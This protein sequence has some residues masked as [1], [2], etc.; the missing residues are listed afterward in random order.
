M[1]A[2]NAKRYGV[3]LFITHLHGG[4][5]MIHQFSLRAI[6]LPLPVEGHRFSYN[7]PP[8]AQKQRRS[9]GFQASSETSLGRRHGSGERW[10][11][12]LDSSSAGIW[13]KCWHLASGN[14]TNAL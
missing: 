13:P 10:A 12:A 11:F 7:Q 9:H 8:Y 14:V 1:L 3:T 2:I 6:A 4:R 5:W